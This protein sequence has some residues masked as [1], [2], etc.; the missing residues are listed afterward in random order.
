MRQQLGLRLDHLG[1]LHLQHLRNALVILLPGAP[2]QRLVGRFLD[3]GVLEE[4]RCLR[5]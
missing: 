1:K 2:Q 3:Q 4:I 5:R